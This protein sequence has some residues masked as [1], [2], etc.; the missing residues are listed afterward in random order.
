MSVE[1]ILWNLIFENICRSGQGHLFEELRESVFAE[2]T[3]L[4]SANGSRSHFLVQL[5]KDLQHISSD[6]VRQ[7]VLQLIQQAV[8][9][10]QVWNI[11]H[12]TAFTTLLNFL[13]T[14]HSLISD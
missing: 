2:M 6:S 8:S 4:I 9:R 13:K 10:Y 1:T 14:S 7:S 3:S 12:V 11:H 5:L